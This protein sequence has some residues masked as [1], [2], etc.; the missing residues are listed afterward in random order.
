VTTDSFRKDVAKKLP[1]TEQFFQGEILSLV[2]HLLGFW[3]MIEDCQLVALFR[4][5]PEDGFNRSNG[6]LKKY[7][8]TLSSRAI[9]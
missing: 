6:Q 7:E 2:F 5:I 4:T 3:F 8:Q 9:A 1:G